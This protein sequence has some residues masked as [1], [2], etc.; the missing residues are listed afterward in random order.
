MYVI[1]RVC[2][3]L[4]FIIDKTKETESSPED[5]PVVKEYIEVFPKELPGLP[6]KREIC[7]EIELI[8]IMTP[9]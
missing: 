8:T 5:I 3:F 7:L 9:I 4:A 2:R 1:K 6:P